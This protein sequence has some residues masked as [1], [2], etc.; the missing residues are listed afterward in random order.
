MNVI[1][2]GIES[3]IT[4]DWTSKRTRTNI[5]WKQIASAFRPF[6]FTFYRQ[7]LKRSNDI[8]VDNTKLT[9]DTVLKLIIVSHTSY[10]MDLRMIVISMEITWN[11][12]QLHNTSGRFG[13][14]ICCS[15]IIDHQYHH[16][17]N[18]HDHH[19]HHPQQRHHCTT[20][21]SAFD[22][23]TRSRCETFSVH[24]QINTLEPH[25]HITCITIFISDEN[26][27]LRRRHNI[28]VVCACQPKCAY[29]NDSR[30]SHRFYICICY[31]VQ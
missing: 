11:F 21:W 7:T 30:G 28:I 17:H 6:G 25:T 3:C 4:I 8:K 1:D 13:S 9:C 24:T 29:E 26:C 16:H 23:P 15:R 5:L 12:Y 31:S 14:N 10:T 27:A 22:F 20:Q 19:H 18:L 2:I